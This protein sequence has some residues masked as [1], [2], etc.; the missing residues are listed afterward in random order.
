MADLELLEKLEDQ[1]DIED[2]RTALEE[3]KEKGTISW[4][5]IKTEEGL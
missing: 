3:V 1:I 5:Q 2:A 4:E